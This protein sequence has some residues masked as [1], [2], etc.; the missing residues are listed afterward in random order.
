MERTINREA[1]C[2][3]SWRMRDEVLEKGTALESG[4][5]VWGDKDKLRFKAMYCSVPKSR[6]EQ[7]NDK[8]T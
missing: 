3:A 5:L 8:K 4:S 1:N 2:S 7:A 6:V